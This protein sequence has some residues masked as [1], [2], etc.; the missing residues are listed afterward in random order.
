MHNGTSINYQQQLL[1]PKNSL[2]NYYTTV[3]ILQ[4]LSLLI[5]YL[6]TELKGST[7]LVPKN[8]SEH[9]PW[10]VPCTFQLTACLLTSKYYPLHSLILQGSVV[11]TVTAYGMDGPGIESRWGRDFPHLSRLALRLTQPP[12][13]WVPGVSWE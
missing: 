13:R 10:T 3:T 6:V 1:L 5:T 8:D 2:C 7:L 12:A 4:I 11:G 9:T